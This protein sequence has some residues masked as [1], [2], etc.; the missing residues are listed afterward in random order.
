MKITLLSELLLGL[1]T[2]AALAQNAP[3]TVNVSQFKNTNGKAR[4]WVLLSG[5]LS[6]R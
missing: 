1:T 3:L 5:Q 2:G 6:H 4:Y